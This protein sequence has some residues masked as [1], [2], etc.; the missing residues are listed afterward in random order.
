LVVMASVVLM[1]IL[2]RIVGLEHLFTTRH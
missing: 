2:D 1:L